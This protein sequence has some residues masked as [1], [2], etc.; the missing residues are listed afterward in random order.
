LIGAIAGNFAISLPTIFFLR[1]TPFPTGIR[2]SRYVK[3]AVDIQASQKA[4]DL[5][6]I[7][8]EGKS[9]GP[10]VKTRYGRPWSPTEAIVD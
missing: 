10:S 1:V 7:F 6:P 2:P 5:S 4:L 8:S 3:S 9:K